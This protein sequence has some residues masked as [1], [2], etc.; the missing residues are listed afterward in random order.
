MRPRIEPRES[1]HILLR[2][3]SSLMCHPWRHQRKCLMLWQ[4][5]GRRITYCY[6]H[7]EWPLRIM[8]FIHSRNVCQKEVITFNRLLE[9]FAQEES[10]LI[11]REENMGATEDLALTIQRR[12]LKRWG[13]WRT[14]FLKN[15]LSILRIW[16]RNDV[17][18]NEEDGEAKRRSLPMKQINI[19]IQFSFHDIV[20]LCI[21]L[22]L[23]DVLY[24]IECLH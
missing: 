21:C 10:W 23:V 5:N 9:E 4:S 19:S 22:Y 1:L 2:I 17:V 12:S 24:M 7:L 8:G 15:L 14:Q 13:I 6:N 20:L 11:I 16:I 18:M 3:I